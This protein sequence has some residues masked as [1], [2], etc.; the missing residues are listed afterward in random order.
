MKLSL[1]QLSVYLF[2]LVFGCGAGVFGSRY[3]LLKNPSFQ[4][5]KNVTM[6]SPP[7]S[8]VPNSSNGGSGSTGGDNVNFIATAVQKV[9]PA[10]V[11]L[12]TSG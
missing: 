12:T 7:E 6:A 10:V 2:L 8:V 9:G 11:K 3:L 4:Q 5:L 1:K